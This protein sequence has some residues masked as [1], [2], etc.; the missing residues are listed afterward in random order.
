MAAVG[1]RPDP[2][3]Q[4]ETRDAREEE[5]YRVRAGG[6]GSLPEGDALRRDP[7][8][9]GAN[10]P[11]PGRA[12]SWRIGGPGERRRLSPRGRRNAGPGVRT[13]GGGI[14]PWRCGAGM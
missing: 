3:E 12:A 8:S 9:V 7:A 14:W 5:K 4:V 6:A 10:S 1:F 11:G 13:G 2:W